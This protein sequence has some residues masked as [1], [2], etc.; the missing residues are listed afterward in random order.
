MSRAATIISASI[1][2]AMENSQCA[3]GVWACV[4]LF[5]SALLLKTHSLQM[6]SGRGMSFLKGRSYKATIFEPLSGFFAWVP[7][8][9][10]IANDFEKRTSFSMEGFKQLSF[11]L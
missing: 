11:R 7:S 6:L 8:S 4:L 1:M 10:K 3:S 9:Q 5:L 2:A